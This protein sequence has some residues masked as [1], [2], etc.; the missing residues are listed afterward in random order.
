MSSVA[1]STWSGRVS[2]AYDLRQ[3]DPTGWTATANLNGP[4]NPCCSGDVAANAVDA[5]A[6]TR[7]STG[8]GQA[9]VWD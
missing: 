1:S 9:P 3:V 8:T 4:A 5:D 6:S 2:D 7:Y